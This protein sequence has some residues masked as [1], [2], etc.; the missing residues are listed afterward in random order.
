[1]D[2]CEVPHASDNRWSID[3][4]LEMECRLSCLRSL[5]C[6]LLKKNEELRHALLEERSGVPLPERVSTTDESLPSLR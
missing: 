1:M 3:S 5:V 4:S 6:E 2:S